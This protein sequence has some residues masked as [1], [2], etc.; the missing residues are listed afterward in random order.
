MSAA[1]KRKD[2]EN[3]RDVTLAYNMAA[4]MMA[5]Q[6]KQGLRPLKYYLSKIKQPRREKQ[7]PE[8]MLANMRQMAAHVNALY[9]QDKKG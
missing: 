4:F 5:A 8:E 7:T 9:S 2:A 6:S 3:E 1:Q